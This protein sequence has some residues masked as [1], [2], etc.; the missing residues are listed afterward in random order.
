M[1][2]PKRL[3]LSAIGGPDGEEQIIQAILKSPPRRGMPCELFDAANSQTSDSNS[4]TTPADETSPPLHTHINVCTGDAE[5]SKLEQ[6]MEAPA[7]TLEKAQELRQII[8]RDYSTANQIGEQVRK[9]WHTT[10]SR[11]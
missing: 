5:W 11:L 9:R 2:R 1:K 6:A 10:V 4:S 3:G 7:E 8:R